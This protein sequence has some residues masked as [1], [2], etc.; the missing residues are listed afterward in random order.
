MQFGVVFLAFLAAIGTTTADACLDGFYLVDTSSDE[1]IRKLDANSD[2]IDLS[3]DAPQGSDLSILAEFCL[4]DIVESVKFNFEEWFRVE[5]EFPFSLGGNK[6][7]NYSAVDELVE[8]G[9]YDLSATAYDQDGANGS[10]LKTMSIS[11]KVVLGS[12]PIVAGFALWDATLNQILE[13]FLVNDGTIYKANYPSDVTFNV[14]AMTDK[15]AKKVVVELIDVATGKTL[16]GRTEKSAPYTVGGDNPK[17]GDIFDIPSLLTTGKAF[18]V[19]ATPYQVGGVKGETASISFR[20]EDKQTNSTEPNPTEPGP[21][22]PPLLTLKSPDPT[23]F[24]PAGPTSICVEL[25]NAVFASASLLVNSVAVSSPTMESDMWCG[26]VNLANGI[27]Y[28]ELLGLDSIGQSLELSTSVWGGSNSITVN[29]FESPGV[30]YNS[31]A[32]V[33]AILSDDN[34]VQSELTTSSGS[35]VFENLPSRTIIF[36]AV[37]SGNEFGSTAG[38]AGQASIEDIT[39]LSFN[40]P[41]AVPNNDFSLG[42]QGWK[43]GLA[44]SVEV[45]PH[46]ENVGPSSGELRHRRREQSLEDQDLLLSTGGTMGVSTVSRTFETDEGVTGVIVRY[47]FVTSEVPGGFFG[48]MY[49]DYFSVSI[50]SQKGGGNVA[51][52]SSM[53]GLGL[54][55][56][57]FASGSTDWRKIKMPIDPDGDTVQVDISVANVGDG[58]YDSYVIVDFIEE[59]KQSLCIYSNVADGVG[60]PNPGLTAGH[61]AILFADSSTEPDTVTTYGLWPDDHPDVVNNGAGTDIRTNFAGDAVVGYPYV[62][63]EPITQQERADLNALVAGN[64]EWTCTNNCASFASETFYDVTG[65]DIDNDDTLGFDTPR[66]IGKSIRAANGGSNIP[67]DGLPFKLNRRLRRAQSSVTSFLEE[68]NYI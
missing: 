45:V 3:V 24:H 62:Y 29:L 59:T 52:A 53:N 65:T 11:L 58:L 47:R 38:V 63:C 26:E 54:A 12:P 2:S 7:D 27:N 49:N 40:P 23:K 64:V 18:T 34:Q 5:N 9:E 20:V 16:M 35:V 13:P 56:F 28:I 8:P 17:T 4:G 19:H 66:E 43:T 32:I 31:E 36:E 37:G 50:R 57:D 30:P 42:L 39:F 48:S 46:E 25:E 60:S 14:E 44:N 55:A 33:K 51:E 67:P 6:G 15:P 10:A 1:Y 61:A 41:S 21:T 68:C 22:E